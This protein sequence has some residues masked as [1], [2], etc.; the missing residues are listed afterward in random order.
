M[1]DLSTVAISQN[2]HQIVNLAEITKPIFS[3][4]MGHTQPIKIG[5]TK[6]CPKLLRI[7]GITK[8]PAPCHFERGRPRQSKHRRWAIHTL[9]FQRPVVPTAHSG[10]DWDP[11]KNIIYT[12]T[13]S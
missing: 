7:Y 11:E 10:D 6:K 3:E 4:N 2:M 8:L 5:I 1:L 9:S 12:F 13:N